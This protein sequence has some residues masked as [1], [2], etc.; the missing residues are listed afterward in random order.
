MSGLRLRVPI[1]IAPLCPSGTSASG[2]QGGSISLLEDASLC[3][4]DLFNNDGEDDFD[5]QFGEETAPQTRTPQN[6]FS[7]PDATSFEQQRIPIATPSASTPIQTPQPVPNASRT[8]PMELDHSNARCMDAASERLVLNTPP[9][10]M[11]PAVYSASFSGLSQIPP[12]QPDLVYGLPPVPEY[13][14]WAA[15]SRLP[16]S[17]ESTAS[18]TSVTPFAN[19]ATSNAIAPH[20]HAVIG[21]GGAGGLGSCFA[22]T[23]PDAVAYARAELFRAT[24]ERLENERAVRVR[25]AVLRGYLGY[26]PG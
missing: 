19:V 20:Q 2:L 1:D 8:L 14:A 17:R 15:A 4:N 23:M 11:N 12:L 16:C 3:I 5:P 22:P 18:Y 6:P 26:P 24:Q 25:E 21:L 9:A 7:T 13:A 10:S